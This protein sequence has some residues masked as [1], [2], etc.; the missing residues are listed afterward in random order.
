MCDG[1]GG[2][3]DGA[4]VGAEDGAA[5]APVVLLQRVRKVVA[6]VLA[7]VLAEDAKVVLVHPLGNPL[8]RREKRS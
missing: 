5:H 3:A 4:D 2:P 7:V 1:P 8:G 6:L